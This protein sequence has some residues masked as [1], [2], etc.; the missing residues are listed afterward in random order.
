MLAALEQL[1]ILQDRDRKL[2]A[3]RAELESLEPQ[4]RTLRLKVES[5]K[6]AGE[7]GRRAVME[8]ETARKK[9][10]LDVETRKQQI[11]KY[12]LQQYQTKKNEEYRA[13]AHEIETAKDAI[14]KIEDDELDLMEQV[15]KAQKE[16]ERLARLA[17]EAK[18]DA[19]KQESDLASREQ[20]LRKELGNYESNRADLAA[21]VE[22]PLLSKYERQRRSKSE[23]VVV[24]IDHGVCG[25]CHV[26]LPAQVL[27][28]CQADQEL[29]TCPNCGRLLYYTRGMSLAAAD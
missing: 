3:L 10:E 27:I 4:R 22:A 2:A 23:R 6:S 1:L 26:K 7:A 21:A 20:N 25:G 5:A 11:E 13:L 8:L 16:A 19:E 9:L 24:G 14:R 18:K 15:E 17:A 29:A 12:T 28:T